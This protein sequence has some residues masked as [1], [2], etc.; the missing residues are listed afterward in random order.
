MKSKLL[1]KILP[2]ILIVVI[3]AT[4]LVFYGVALNKD[5]NLNI[6]ET[7]LASTAS[8]S[9]DTGSKLA[10]DDNMLTVW[11]VNKK[12]MQAVV[13]FDEFKNINALLINENGYNVRQFSVYYNDGENWKLCYRQNEIG[14]NRLATF[15]TVKAKAIKIVIDDFKNIA[16]ISDIKMYCL[17]DKSQVDVKKFDHIGTLYLAY[18]YHIDISSPYFCYRNIFFSFKFPYLSLLL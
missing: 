8:I 10:F 14:I 15:Y 4:L 13:E 9:G 18:M 17:F 2:I 1:I 16:R 7:N 5:N 3:L 12:G 6:T 11:S